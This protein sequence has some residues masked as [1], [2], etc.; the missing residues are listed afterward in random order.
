MISKIVRRSIRLLGSSVL[1]TVLLVVVMVYSAVAT[2]IPQGSS[3]DA[4]V[5][6]WVASHPLLGAVTRFLG[7]HSAF[8]S[9]AFLA[10]AFLLALSA[11]LCSWRRTKVAIHRAGAQRE[12]SEVDASSLAEVSDVVISCDPDLS[13]SEVLD[14][15][16]EELENLGIRT[17]RHDDLLRASSPAWAVWGSPVFHWAL[18]GFM[19]MIVIAPLQHTDG[20]MGLAVG[21]VKPHS[22]SSYGFLDAGS[23]HAWEPVQRKLRLDGFE[24]EYVVGGLD[25]GPT[26]TVSLLDSNDAVVKTQH[27]YPN[28]PLKSGSLTVHADTYGLAVRLTILDAADVQTAAGIQYVDFATDDPAGTRPLG[29]V[30]LR[31]KG[32]VVEAQVQVTIPLDSKEGETSYWMPADPAARL[33]VTAPDGHVIEDRVVSPGQDLK[34]ALGQTVRVDSIDWYY[35]LS[36]V[37]DSTTPVIYALLIVAFLGLTVSLVSRQQVLVAARIETP[38]GPMLAL[39]VRLWRNVPCDREAIVERLIV[40]LGPTQRGNN[41]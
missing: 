30:L 6:A 14:R 5:A 12:A 22:P 1:A 36:V 2:F 9:F 20:L 35:R 15:V 38:E 17:K 37:D 4:A 32:G 27:V 24:S 39:R 16:S 33:L 10:C 40:R 7:M 21:E 31:G 19:V 29:G 3:G 11:V 41:S 25:R 28:S 18:V 26:P 23:L 34:L 8:A 13:S